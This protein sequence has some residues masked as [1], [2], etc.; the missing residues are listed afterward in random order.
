M[1][2]QLARVTSKIQ[3]KARIIR[4]A[5]TRLEIFPIPARFGKMGRTFHY[6]CTQCQYHADISGGADSGLN[7][8]VQTIICREL[9]GIIRRFYACASRG[10]T[11]GICA[12]IF[13]LHAIGNST[14]HLAEQFVRP[15]TRP[16]APLLNG[17]NKI[18]PVRGRKT[19]RRTLEKIPDA[20]RAVTPSW[21]KSALPFRVWE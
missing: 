1:V 12:Q 18:G 13:Q 20:A 6:H 4:F 11:S 7:C 2:A 9:P 10:G 21:N 19:F 15:K 16:T 3:G 17:K 14:R 8:E 5:Q